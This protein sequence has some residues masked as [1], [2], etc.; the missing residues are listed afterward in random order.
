M[1]IYS[2]IPNVIPDT[3]LLNTIALPAD[4]RLLQ[5]TDLPQLADELR[6]FLL[7]SVGQSGGHFGAG[8]GVIELTIALHYVFDTP[9]DTLIWDVGHQ[10]Y[11]HKILS[12]R[13]E[14]LHTIRQQDG[15]APFPCRKESDYDA[16]GV[17]H[18]GTS[19]SA[20]LGMTL[21][22]RLMDDHKRHTV[23]VIGD[24]AITAGMTFEALNH[25]GAAKPDL[26]IVLND[27]SMSISANVG[28]FSNYCARIFS[29]NTY[30]HIR[31]GIKKHLNKIPF[32]FKW[33]QRSE[34][35]MKGLVAPPSGLFEA[36]GCHYIGPIDGHHL[37]TLV[38]TLRNMKRLEGVQILHIKT[39]KGRGFTP[40]EANPV[41]Y[42]ALS[43]IPSAAKRQQSDLEELPKYAQIF[44]R[45]LCTTARHDS[46]LVGITPA[47]CEGSDLVDFAKE[48][49]QRYIDVG[50]A[51][52]H[53]VTLAAGFAARGMKPVVAIY[54]TFL[55]RAYDQLI[56]DVCLQDL[57]VLFAIDRA[58]VVGEDGPTHNGSFDLGFLRI[59]PKMVVMTPAD[60]DA[61][62][63]LL[64]TGY[65]YQG[66]A[67]VRYPRGAVDPPLPDSSSV[68]TSWTIGKAQVIYR[69]STPDQHLAI[70]VFGPLLHDLRAWAQDCDHTLVDMRF[71]KPLDR[72]QVSALAHSHAGLVTVEDHAVLGG[73]GGAV[74]E[75]LT[76]LRII[77]P[78][79]NLGLPDDFI[80]HASRT[81]MLANAGLDAKQIAARIS[82]WMQ[83][84]I[85]P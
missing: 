83:T 72:T 75:L 70:L 18:A 62:H 47:M 4:L 85:D 39:T 78:I 63:Q 34:R 41:G 21:A 60:A 46:R 77:C 79:L 7:Y 3:P 68:T 57:D 61:L 24:G 23:A 55:Q 26:L 66:P 1:K 49:P 31:A 80:A 42:H 36:L 14:R 6:A 54:S 43:K 82:S 12:G 32:L 76:N 13:R 2:A 48:F 40:A 53:A 9:N 69:S 58:G 45:W 73:G 84:I 11:P 30:A 35:Q 52:Q 38:T 44:G 22:D 8:L 81:Q 5:P 71:V 33:M 17:G 74:N 51:E 50:I 29:G 67:A 25:A 65:H 10:S 19:I 64:T 16:F 28:A 59:I 15:L 20:A 27:N 37:P 56:H